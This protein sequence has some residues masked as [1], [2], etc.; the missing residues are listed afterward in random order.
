M[1]D[2]LSELRNALGF[3]FSD[4]PPV[5]GEFAGLETLARLAGRGSQ[6]HFTE[7]P[8]DADL[9]RLLA[10]VALAA[11]TKSDLQQRDIVCI[12]D[13]ALRRA[14]NGLVAEQAWVEKAP[15]LL[16]FCGNNRRQRLIHDWRGRRF[17]NDH[18]DAFFN[19]A[20]D[21][22]IALGAFVSAAEAAGLG[23]C[24]VSAI[25]DRAQ[26]VSDLLALP[27][28]V[29]PLAGLAVGWPAA[30]ATVS[31]RLPLSATVHVDRYDPGPLRETVAAYDR[32]RAAAQ[33]YESQRFTEE[34]GVADDYG[35]SEDKAR[36]YARPERAD[37]GAFVRR[38]GFD[39]S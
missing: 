38:K 13:P 25:R 28:H 33:P 35:W 14:I 32:E 37:F 22:A 36:Q 24:P 21:A 3:R 5:A 23:C 8:V 16:V 6:R 11:P 1:T 39:L 34:F 12:A 30:P 4:A 17:V 26:E 15:A 20:V 9:L 18:L 2:A 27:Q 10:A 29:F 19:A 31:K 7:A